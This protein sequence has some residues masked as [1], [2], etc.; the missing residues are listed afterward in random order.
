MVEVALIRFVVDL[1]TAFDPLVARCKRIQSPVNE[2][3]EA[4]MDEPRRIAARWRWGQHCRLLSN[5]KVNGATSV[6]RLFVHHIQQWFAAQIAAQI[7]TE[8][9]DDAFAGTR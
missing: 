9:V 8:Y 2:H 3:A 6:S 4:I 1:L 5:W 7:L